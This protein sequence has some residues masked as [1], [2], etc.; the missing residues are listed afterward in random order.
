MTEQIAM[1]LSVN[2]A[3]VDTACEPRTLLVHLLRE[4]L[5]L[6]GTHVGCDTSSCGACAVLLDGR[7]VKSC[8]VLAVQAAG[9]TVVTVEGLGEDGGLGAVQKS[10]A[11]HHAQQ[12][13]FCTP[14]F[15]IA[16]TAALADTNGVDLTE[17]DVRHRL[18]GNLC[19]C[20]GYAHIV[21]AVLEAAQTT[22]SR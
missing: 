9:R 11:E 5:A 4:Q 8:T 16:A 14:G 13:G 15:L 18:S 19:R 20:T 3:P 10:F 7:P 6:T 21:E 12:C 2:G 22:R 17:E 1:S